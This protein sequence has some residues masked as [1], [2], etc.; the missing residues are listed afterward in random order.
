M[1][2]PIIAC[3][4]EVARALEAAQMLEADG[5]SARVVNMAT[6]KPEDL[7]HVRNAIAPDATGGD[8][9]A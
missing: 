9:S 2:L 5:I 7:Y 4:A 3:G 1:F 8:S 6:I